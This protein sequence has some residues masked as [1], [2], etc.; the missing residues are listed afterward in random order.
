MIPAKLLDAT[1]YP[2]SADFL[3][4]ST[5]SEGSWAKPSPKC[6]IVPIKHCVSGSPVSV[7]G[8]KMA[9]A[10]STPPPILKLLD[11]SEKA[12]EHPLTQSVNHKQDYFLILSNPWLAE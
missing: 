2:C 8:F 6:Y 7:N 1:P 9:I 5:A 10:I 3:Y 11:N 12:A 4:H